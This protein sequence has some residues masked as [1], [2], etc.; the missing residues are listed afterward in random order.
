MQTPEKNWYCVK[1]HP[2]KERVAAAAL[3]RAGFE[4]VCSPV[5]EAPRL[6]RAGKQWFEEP[7]FPGYLFVRFDARVHLRTVRY[8]HGVS[9]VVTF[10]REPAIVPS[11]EILSLKHLTQTS[12]ERLEAGQ[13]VTVICGALR[14][15]AA[16]IQ[17]VYGAGERVRILIDFLGREQMLDVGCDDVLAA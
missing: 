13:R 9:R 12:A 5:I 10:G 11:D 14:G 8:A 15:L 16:R 7:L 6:T 1:T 2:R 4:E 17:N 3:R